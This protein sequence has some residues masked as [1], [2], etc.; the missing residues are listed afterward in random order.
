MVSGVFVSFISSCTD[1]PL[2]STY[3]KYAL[4]FFFHKTRVKWSGLAEISG[5]GLTLNMRYKRYTAIIIPWVSIKGFCCMFVGLLSSCGKSKVL[6]DSVRTEG[7]QINQCSEQ[8]VWIKCL[9][10]FSCKGKICHSGIWIFI[11]FVQSGE[12]SWNT[13]SCTN[14]N[15]VCTH[16]TCCHRHADAGEEGQVVAGVHPVPHGRQ[17]EGGSSGVNGTALVA[18]PADRTHTVSVWTQQTHVETNEKLHCRLQ[19][20]I[21][22]Y[23]M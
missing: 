4:G 14:R 23:S 12:K 7:K 1:T 22:D 6:I 19:S 3:C 17:Q 8:N 2:V 16:C 9:I 5:N 20:I 13:S 18:H 10:N 11:F 21:S 15:S